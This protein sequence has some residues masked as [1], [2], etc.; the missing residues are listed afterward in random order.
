V[1]DLT[2][3]YINPYNVVILLRRDAVTFTKTIYIDLDVYK[4][5][6]ANRI[7]FNEDHNTILRR[8]LSLMPSSDQPPERPRQTRSSG[9]Y[10]LHLFG[11]EIGIKNVREALSTALLKVESA[12]PGFLDKLSKRQTAKGRRIV[13]RKPEDI[14][15]NR[16]QLTKW[17][18][19]LNSEWYFDTNIS[20]ETCARY[21]EI[22]ASVAGIETPRLV[23][24]S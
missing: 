14:H 9:E 13:S 24:R 1:D 10:S 19:P 22:I 20:R 4:A 3:V 5:L 23:K 8:L 21:L 17:A 7:S 2:R 12:K 18:Y 16:P 6:E 15:P 11:E